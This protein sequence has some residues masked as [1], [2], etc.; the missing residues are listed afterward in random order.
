[1]KLIFSLV[2]C[3]LFFSKAFSQNTTIIKCD[4]IY[5]NKGITIK[6]AT[7]N[8]REDIEDDEKNATLTIT[9]Q[10]NGKKTIL[11]KENLHSS[12]QE[13]EF[14]DFNND[15]IKDLLVQNYSDARSNWTYSLYLYNSKA[16]N[17]KKVVGF[18]EIK[19]PTL[20]TKYNIIES[21][22]V[23]GTNW[24]SFYKIKN[25]KVIDFNIVIT[26]DGSSKSEKEY[27][28]AIKKITSIK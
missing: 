8:D 16:N 23:S 22:V 1:M 7:F 4:S 15:K 25:N 5:K 19:N 3:L 12:N 10:L 2:T 20:N 6:L 24:A 28:K 26:D 17:F 13:I 27:R 18:E 9:Q 14:R 21:H 11:V